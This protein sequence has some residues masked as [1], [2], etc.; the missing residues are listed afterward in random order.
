MSTGEEIERRLSEAGLA[1]PEARS[2]VSLFDKA[3]GALETLSDGRSREARRW[4][5]P[6]RIEVLGKHTDYAGGRSL[7]CTVERGFCLAASR[8]SDRR[9]RILD[10]GR[11]LRAELRLA[12]D[13]APVEGEW[14]VYPQV[15]A[16]RVARN[17]PGELDGADIAFAS[18]LP[19]AAGLSSSSA[20]VVALFTVLAD[21]N[22][23]DARPEFQSS[24]Q[25]REDLAEYLG[26]L[27]NGRDFRSLPGDRG[28]GTLGGSED[29]TAILCC[30]PGELVQYVF[31]P[32]RRERAVPLPEDW[33]FVVASSGVASDK[34]G[35]VREK[36]NRLSLAS[37]VVLDLWREATGREDRSLFAAATST[38]DAPQR[39]R[40]I[41]GDSSHRD[42]SARVLLDRFDQFFQESVEI[43]PEAAWALARGDA[44]AFGNL[45]DRSQALAELRLG[46]QVPE[47]AVLARGARSLG[48]VAA[49]AFGGGFGGSVWA[50]VSAGDA[51]AFRSHW[52][53]AYSHVFAASAA[54]AEFFQTRPG[55]GL[56]RLDG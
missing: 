54:R 20:F 36:Y 2:K 52:G 37:G 3:A 25:S 50:L 43:V 41:L 19:A 34:T 11:G 16:R 39:M 24:I 38:P 12:P 4:F 23:L 13:L 18:D 31:C 48:A 30:R 26:C 51:E 53:K 21:F 32:V 45:V 10:A 1:G 29:H 55:P 17:F 5:V 22:N 35:S 7:L 8:R 47:T 56:L 14:A 44:A 49:S 9:L 6:G 15:V 33:T 28:V 42:F 40:E 27:E 46:N